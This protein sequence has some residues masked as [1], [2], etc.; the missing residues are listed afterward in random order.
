ML[1]MRLIKRYRATI[2]EPR[3]TIQD[4][5]AINEVHRKINGRLRTENK[6]LRDHLKHGHWKDNTNGTFTCSV[7]GGK[8]SKMAWCGL[9]GAKM[10][11]VTKE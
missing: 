5:R 7:C 4:L 6:V 1:I 2:K 9:C 8:A 11:E 3:A 10:D